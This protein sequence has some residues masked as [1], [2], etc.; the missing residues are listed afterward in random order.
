MIVMTFPI[1]ENGFF[2][3][4]KQLLAASSVNLDCNGMSVTVITMHEA[5]AFYNY[6]AMTFSNL[7]GAVNFLATV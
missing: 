1:A 2:C 5:V 6:H 4:W 3:S 7:I